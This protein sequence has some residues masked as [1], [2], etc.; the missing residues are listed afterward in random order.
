MATI[1][2]LDVVMTTTDITA[3]VVGESRSVTVPAGTVGT[4]VIV[5]TMG[6]PLASLEVEFFLGEFSYALA[7]ARVDQIVHVAKI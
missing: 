5:H 6:T 7:S 4:V 3:Q 2:E 1:A